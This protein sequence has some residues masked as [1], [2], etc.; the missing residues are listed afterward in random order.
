MTSTTPNDDVQPDEQLD[1]K[2]ASCPMPV[3]K[4]KQASDDLS[5]GEVLEVLATDNGSVSDIDGWAAGTPGVELVGQS[6]REEDGETVYV[7]HVRAVEQ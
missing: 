5:P 3:V 6:E 4:T 1:V 2:G 7:H